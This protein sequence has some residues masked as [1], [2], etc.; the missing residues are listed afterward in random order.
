[1]CLQ[2]RYEQFLN[3]RSI[4]F[5]QNAKHCF[6]SVELPTCPVDYG[7][8]LFCC[9][10][11]CLGWFVF[12]ESTKGPLFIFFQVLRSS[13]GGLYILKHYKN[14]IFSLKKQKENWQVALPVLSFTLPWSNGIKANVIQDWSSSDQYW[15]GELSAVMEMR[16]VCAVWYDSHM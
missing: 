10:C 11:S 13:S 8:F 16:K 14:L 2:S 3:S 4:V 12:F 15:A 5:V 7:R 6:L 9:S 1:M